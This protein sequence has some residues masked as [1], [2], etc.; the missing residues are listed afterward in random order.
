MTQP[1]R[2]VASPST[3]KG[4]TRGAESAHGFP[5][6]VISRDYAQAPN[7]HPGQRCA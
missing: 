4:R 6:T 3:L 1:E 2:G 7:L 5:Q